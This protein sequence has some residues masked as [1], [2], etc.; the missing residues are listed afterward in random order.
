MEF[1]ICSNNLHKLAEIKRILAELGLKA[2]SPK[3]LGI[4][5]GEIEETGSTFVE[6]AEIKALV[7]LDR[8]RLASIADDSG[9][10]VDALDGRPGVYTARYGGEGLDDRGRYELLLEEMKNVPDEQRTAHFVSSVCVAFKNGD[11]LIAEGSCDGKIGYSP[12]GENG[13]GY[14]P[15]FYI[16]D[17]SFAQLSAEE[18]DSISHRGKALELLKEKLSDYLSDIK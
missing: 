12:A 6:N 14:D 7:G 11:K 1:L 8:S 5:L 16:G 4:D 10:C 17:R 3:E 9:L 2:Y 18:K 13:F 15:V